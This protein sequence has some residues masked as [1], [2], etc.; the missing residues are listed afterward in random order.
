M[1]ANAPHQQASWAIE[2]RSANEREALISWTYIP[3]LLTRAISLKALP[4][5][6]RT[7]ERLS[8][9]T[10][11]GTS[12]VTLPWS[13]EKCPLLR[14]FFRYRKDGNE[15]ANVVNFRNEKRG[16]VHAGSLSKCRELEH[17]DGAGVLGWKV[18]RREGKD[19]SQGQPGVGGFA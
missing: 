2:T 3:N 6:C 18:S 11:N 1:T 8:R 16:P 10:G 9:R 14:A 15:T 12:R 19:W 4:T 13:V 5:D 17:D 7:N